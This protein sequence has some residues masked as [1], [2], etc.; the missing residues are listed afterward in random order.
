LN[1]SHDALDKKS[2]VLITTGA[3]QT[4]SRERLTA[5]VAAK[6][7][8]KC[9]IVSIGRSFR[10]DFRQHPSDRI[11]GAE[12]FIKKAGAGI[13]RRIAFVRNIGQKLTRNYENQGEKRYTCCTNGRIV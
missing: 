7:G 8:M 4:K 1:T 12:D 10:R 3:P 11:M 6:Y 9:A 5:A 2:T 13:S